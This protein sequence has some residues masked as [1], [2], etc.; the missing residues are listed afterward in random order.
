MEENRLNEV[1]DTT[2]SKIRELDGHEFVLTDGTRIPISRG[3]RDKAREAFFETFLS[4]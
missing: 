2:I 3:F 1:M 4:I